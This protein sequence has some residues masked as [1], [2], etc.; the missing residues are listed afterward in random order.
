MR[1]PKLT[2]KQMEKRLAWCLANQHREWKFCIWAD[3]THFA[4]QKS[5]NVHNDIVWSSSSAN[6]PPYETKKYPTHTKCC[7][8]LSYKHCARS[9]FYL[10][11]L[12]SSDF[13]DM[14]EKTKIVKEPKRWIQYGQTNQLF[15]MLDGDSAHKGEFT[16]WAKLNK[17]EVVLLPPQSPDLDPAENFIS[18]VN[19]QIDEELLLS[20]QELEDAI[21]ESLL[22]VKGDTLKHLA[23]SMSRRVASIIEA[24]GDHIKKY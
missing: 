2:Q 14:I 20:K 19:Q 23:L 7:L 9:D 15:L 8:F 17:L 24:N 1:R 10:G 12:S 18:V 4:F 6:V 5:H 16:K 3:E 13:R 22:H 21:D 11:K